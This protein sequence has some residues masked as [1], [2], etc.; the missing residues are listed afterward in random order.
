MAVVG[1]GQTLFLAKQ[2]YTGEHYNKAATEISARNPN[3]T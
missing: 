1:A 3:D 2:L